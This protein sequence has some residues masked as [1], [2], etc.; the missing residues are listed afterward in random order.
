MKLVDRTQTHAQDRTIHRYFGEVYKWEI[1]YSYDIYIILK[2]PRIR[3][4]D[5]LWENTQ[6][7]IN[8][9]LS[10]YKIGINIC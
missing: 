6:E 3:K 1:K 4:A 10:N 7:L 9:L 5:W 2:L 8:L